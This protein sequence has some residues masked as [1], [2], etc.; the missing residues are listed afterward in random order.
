LDERRIKAKEVDSNGHPQRAFFFN[1][2]FTEA[3][4]E[5]PHFLLNT[6][7]N[8]S[9]DKI[10]NRVFGVEV[11]CGSIDTIFLYHCDQFIFGGANT[12]IEIQRQAMADLGHLLAQDGHPFPRI[13]NYQFDN[14]SE[15]K[16]SHNME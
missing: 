9:M 13:V 5:I 11:T 8:K 1:D 12:L 16:V 15:N 2:A 3:K 10:S 14:C 6:S 4:G 7:R